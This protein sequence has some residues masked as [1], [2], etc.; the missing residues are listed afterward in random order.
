MSMV[1]KDKDLVLRNAT[2]TYAVVTIG[3]MVVH[4]NCIA[5]TIMHVE[6]CVPGSLDQ[7]DGL[8]FCLK[9]L[10]RIDEGNKV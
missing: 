10:K 4:I 8:R 2:V 3:Q 5:H 7:K 9:W 1:V 6:K